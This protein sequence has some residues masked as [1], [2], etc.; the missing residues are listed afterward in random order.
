MTALLHLLLKGYIMNT[1]FVFPGQGSQTVGMGQELYQ[2]FSIAKQVFEEVDDALNLKLSDLMFSGDIAELTQT[3]N[4][5]PAIMAVPD[6]G[7]GNGDGTGFHTAAGGTR[8]GSDEHEDHCRQK[9]GIRERS[10]IERG[11][12]GSPA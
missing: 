6:R 1:A 4:V 7:G 12:S 10:D 5:Q 3:E 8:R 2:Q 11:K 9:S